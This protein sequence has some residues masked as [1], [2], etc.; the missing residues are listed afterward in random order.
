MAAVP[1]LTVESGE[2]AEKLLCHA[3]KPWTSLRLVQSE[4]RD[5]LVSRTS[6][7]VLFKGQ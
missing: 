4:E 3:F 5:R 2:K 6:V 1:P 7:Q